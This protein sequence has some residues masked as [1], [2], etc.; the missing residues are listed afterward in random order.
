MHLTPSTIRNDAVPPFANSAIAINN[1][2]QSCLLSCCFT[3][4]PCQGLELGPIHVD[5]PG[6]SR[7]PLREEKLGDV[8]RPLLKLSAE[9]S[10][11]CSVTSGD[12]GAGA[13]VAGSAV[14]GAATDDSALITRRS[15]ERLGCSAPASDGPSVST[16]TEGFPSRVSGDDSGV[17]RTVTTTSG[18][19][20]GG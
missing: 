15:G 14:L 19:D 5:M 3:L 20:G 13:S 9:D 6:D 12:D 10:A 7:P 8:L 4:R 17:S 18:D 16:S 1:N 11:T 2:Q